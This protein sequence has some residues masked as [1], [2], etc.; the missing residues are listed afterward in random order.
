MIRQLRCRKRGASLLES[1]FVP[2]SP[3]QLAQF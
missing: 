1:E 2:I 3:A